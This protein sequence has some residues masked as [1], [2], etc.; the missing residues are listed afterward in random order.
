MEYHN[1]LLYIFIPF[2]KLPERKTF[3]WEEVFREKNLGNFLLKCKLRL[4]ETLRALTLPISS[5]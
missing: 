5:R 3:S 1:R 4:C 2:V